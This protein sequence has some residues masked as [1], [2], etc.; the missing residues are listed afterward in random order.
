ME[1][2]D[3]KISAKVLRYFPL[4]PRLQRLFMSSETSKLMRWHHEERNKDGVLRHPVDS[5]AWKSFDNKYPEF[6]RDAR[7][8]HL[9]LASD[10]FN[11]FGTMRTV[12][13]TWPVIIMPYNLPP[14]MCM[15]EEFFILS[16]LI[17]G[18]KWPGN[19]IDV[20]LEPLIEELIELWDVRVEIYDAF[21]KET[22]K[23][24]AALMWTINDFSAY[25]NLF[26]WC[27]Y[28]KFACRSCNINTESRRLKHGIFFL[29][30]G[31]STFLEAWAQILK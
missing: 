19:N 22:F 28:S 26:G 11:P 6:A 10:G 20:F 9:G 31:P 15:K 17:P 8:I 5:E 18:P 2:I 1:K 23:M 14:W 3:R 16:L 25:G 7:N 27:T 21:A 24:R 29:L 30:Y 12:H 4:K 13:S